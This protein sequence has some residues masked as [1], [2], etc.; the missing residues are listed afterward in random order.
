MASRWGRKQPEQQG[1]ALIVLEGPDKG[2]EFPV[3]DELTIGRTQGNSVVRLDRGVSRNHCRI[4][5]EGGVFTIEDFNSANGTLVNDKK[6]EALEVLRHGDRILIGETTYLFHWPDGAI[7]TGLSTSPGLGRMADDTQPGGGTTGE[8]EKPKKSLLKRPPMIIALVVVL[9]IVLGGLL[10]VLLGDGEALG[11]SDLSDEPIHYSES[12]EFRQTAFGLGNH[13]DAHPDK[14]IVVFDYLGGRASLR[15]SAWGITSTGEVVIRLNGETVGDI[16]MTQEYRHELLLELP[17]E[18]LREGT[19][20]LE[21][22]NTRNP[23]AE[24]PWEVGYI[25]IVHEPLLPANPEEAQAQYQ[26][27]LRYYEDREVDPANRYRAFEKFRM[28]RN[29]LEQ[30]T[31]RPPMYDEATAM[32]DRAMEELQEL[33]QLGRFSAERSYRFGDVD[34]ARGYLRRTLRYFP[35]A[36][37]VRRDQLARALEGLEDQ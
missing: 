5:D 23:P 28:T 8:Q 13:D 11:P 7:D 10:K 16:G 25:R 30:A 35:H 34:Q 4:K 9:L 18:H 36:D 32:M 27:G 31:P 2:S 3:A 37:D 12:M 24:D 17:T 20:Q 33:F 1:A 29:L 15:Y 22:D 6:L 14:A 26:L 19:N 21:F